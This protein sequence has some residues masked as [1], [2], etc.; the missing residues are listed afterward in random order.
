MTVAVLMILA[1]RSTTS[2][3]R[4]PGICAVAGFAR[5]RRPAYRERVRSGGKAGRGRAHLV[6]EARPSRSAEIRERERRYLLIMGIRLACFITAG[7]L[8]LTH[9]GWLALIP[10][11]GSIALPYF[12]VVIANSRR[13]VGSGD[14]RAYQPRLPDRFSPPAPAGPPGSPAS[15][16]PSASPAQPTPPASPGPS[17]SPAPPMAADGAGGSGGAGGGTPEQPPGHAGDGTGGN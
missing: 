10:A 9:A 4:S 13:P 8:F 14:F 16:G 17:A 12:A 6:T 2:G 15:P 5:R 1:G 11:A 3:S 7:I